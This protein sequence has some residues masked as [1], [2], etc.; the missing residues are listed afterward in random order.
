[1]VKGKA[2][3][4]TDPWAYCRN[5]ECEYYGVDVS[6]EGTGADGDS[7]KTA[8]APKAPAAPKK[9]KAKDKK[10]KA[11]AKDEAPPEPAKKKKKGKGKKKAKTEE[12]APKVKDKKKNGMNDKRRKAIIKDIV[13]GD[14]G[15]AE[16]IHKHKTSRKTVSNIIKELKAEGA[17]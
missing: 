13:S 16:I 11:K 10:K 4:T 6:D 5:A 7:G 3:K 15:V 9:E 2:V 8:P 14:L 12:P 17:L 1:M